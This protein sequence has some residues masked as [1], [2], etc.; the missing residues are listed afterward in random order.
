MT[1]YE[2]F[3]AAN[4]NNSHA[5]YQNLWGAQTFTIGNTGTNEDFYLQG[6]NLRGR[7]YSAGS[8]YFSIRETF[9][10]VPS[11]VDLACGSKADSEI[12]AYISWINVDLGSTI[13]LKKDTKYAII[14]RAPL[15]ESMF[16]PIQFIYGVG[17]EGG[18]LYRSS[19]AG[20]EGT[21]GIQPNSIGFKVYGL[22]AGYKVWYDFSN[23]NKEFNI[24]NSNNDF[25][26]QNLNSKNITLRR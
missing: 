5:F 14:I 17:Y 9:N 20:S 4:D 6:I 15:S 3:I 8:S 24:K 16:N 18:R 21:W 10:S 7:D 25:V 23:T 13:L 1:I 12:P 22:S 11:G 26:L 19:N 2:S